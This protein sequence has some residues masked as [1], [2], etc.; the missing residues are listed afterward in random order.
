VERSRA[1]R[2]RKRIDEAYDKA[3]KRAALKGR[4]IPPKDEYYT[5]WGYPYAYYGPYI[6]P[7]WYTPGLY[8]GGCPGEMAACAEGA[9][10]AC[11]AGTCGGTV[12]SGGCVSSG[13]GGGVDGGSGG[14]ECFFLLFDVRCNC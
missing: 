7:V 1:A 5:Q 3:Q 13:A 4:K 8:V 14:G 6:C 9:S 2:H 10:G 12:A 11:V